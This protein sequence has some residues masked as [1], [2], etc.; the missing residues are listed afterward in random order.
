MCDADEPIRPVT[1]GVSGRFGPCP[2]RDPLLRRGPAFRAQSGDLQ[3]MCK[4]LYG[5][6]AGG[7]EGVVVCALVIV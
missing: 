4:V 2:L 1:G 3:A 6:E 7:L 5:R